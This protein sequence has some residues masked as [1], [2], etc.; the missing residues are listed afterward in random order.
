MIIEFEGT[1]ITREVAATRCVWDAR[2]EGRVP[3]LSLR[4][5]DKGG[6]WDS[7]SPQPGNRVSV[8]AGGAAATGDLFVKTCAPIAGGYE[9]RADA[10]PVADVQAIREWRQ[11]TLR[12]MINM[13][14]KI[15]HRAAI[16][17]IIRS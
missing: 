11:T 17:A 7:W 10:L 5:D 13:M 3:Q 2:E 15:R 9:M 4:F 16:P 6:L 1:D 8:S 12:V 14:M